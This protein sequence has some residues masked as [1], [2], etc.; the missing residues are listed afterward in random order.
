M[1]EASI[2]QLA[3][4]VDI[5]KDRYELAKRRLLAALG[6]SDSGAQTPIA[7]HR[8]TNGLPVSQQVLKA[9][10]GAPAG[11]SRSDLRSRIQGSESSLHSF[12]KKGSSKGRILNKDGRWFLAGDAPKK[13]G[14]R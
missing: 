5:A 2:E 6:A 4:D 1:A 3:R 7:P 9:L 8:A 13:K 10:A 12:L 14:P 11:L